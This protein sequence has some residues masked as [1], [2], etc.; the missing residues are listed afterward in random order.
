MFEDQVF[1][2]TDA[3]CNE[4]VPIEAIDKVEMVSLCSDESTNLNLQEISPIKVFANK[5]TL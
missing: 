4:H 2:T 1:G 5:V 3:R